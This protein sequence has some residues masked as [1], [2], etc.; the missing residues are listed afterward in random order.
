[1][2]ILELLWAEISQRRMKPVFVVD[3]LDEVRKL[4]DDVLEGFESHWVDS[5]GLQRFHEALGLC[6]VI[7]IAS[8]PHGAEQTMVGKELAVDLGGIL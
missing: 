4:L 5:L 2:L 6:V 3:L 8:A 7:G 1:V